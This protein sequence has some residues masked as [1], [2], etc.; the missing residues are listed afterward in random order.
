MPHLLNSPAL[1]P[2]PCPAGSACQASSPSSAQLGALLPQQRSL[3]RL[4]S[5][6]GR[7]LQLQAQP[8]RLPGSPCRLLLP[9]CRSDQG[10]SVPSRHLPCPAWRDHHGRLLSLR[11][12]HYRR[13]SWGEDMQQVRRKRLDGAPCWAEQL[14]A[15]QPEAACHRTGAAHPRRGV[16]RLLLP[17]AALPSRYLLPSQFLRPE[18]APPPLDSHLLFETCSIDAR[19][20]YL[21]QNCLN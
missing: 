2:Q 7:H 5:K 14:L 18:M 16:T 12:Q 11:H 3:G 13:R 10:H 1:L 19:Y 4:P 9:R 17:V 8:G 20:M 6:H 21:T 15:P